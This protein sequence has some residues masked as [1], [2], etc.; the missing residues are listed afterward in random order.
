MWHEELQEV[1]TRASTT[2]LLSGHGQAAKFLRQVN[3]CLPCLFSKSKLLPSPEKGS[4][5]KHWSI[6]FF[7][8]S[9]GM[10]L[11]GESAKS[12]P[13]WF[14]YCYSALLIPNLVSVFLE[15]ILFC[16]SFSFGNISLR[17]CMLVYILCIHSKLI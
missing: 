16:P 15:P 10:A 11:H 5:W 13:K 8:A 6:H 7:P 9:P 17:M 4:N 3:S 1:T 2:G 14:C 12:D